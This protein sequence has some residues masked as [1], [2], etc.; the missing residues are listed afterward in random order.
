[1]RDLQQRRAAAAGQERALAGY[2]PDDRGVVE[3]AVLHYG[4]VDDY[5]PGV[6]KP[7]RRDATR[8]L[9][10][11]A[12]AVQALAARALAARALA[13]SLGEILAARDTSCARY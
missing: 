6:K 7:R 9:A 10:V 11:R 13:A 12:L 1:M 2:P 4:N 8:A 3:E 5:Q